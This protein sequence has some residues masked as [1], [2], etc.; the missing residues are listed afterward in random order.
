MAPSG[1]AASKESPQLLGMKRGDIHLHSQA[2]QNQTGQQL[3]KWTV[4]V[5]LAVTTKAE[6]CPAETAGR[7]D[8]L[9][10]PHHPPHPLHHPHPVH[11]ASRQILPFRDATCD[12]A[13][14]YVA[15]FRRVPG[16]Q[17]GK[18]GPAGPTVRPRLAKTEHSIEV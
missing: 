15:V 4:T 16:K 11:Q 5:I 13:W 2:V 6:G 8:S 10:P 7:P 17:E 9:H 1:S 18:K 12:R 14:A 3:R